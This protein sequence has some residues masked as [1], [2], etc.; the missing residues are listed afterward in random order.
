[1]TFTIQDDA[2]I[3]GDETAVLTISNP[4]AGVT[5]GTTTTQN[6]AI[7]DNDFPTVELSVSTN[8]GTEAAGTVVTVTAT[9]SQAVDGDQT[10]DLGVSGTGIAN[11]D[12]TLSNATITILDGATTDMVTFTVQD[13]ADIEGDETAMLTISNP[14]AGVT[15]GTT[16]TQNVAITDNDFPTV[17]LSVSANSGTE[18]AG[19]VITVTATASQAVDGD[20]TVDLGVSGTG[21]ANTDYT[22]SNATITI[23]DGATTG[24]V[25][26][27]IQ[28]DAD[29]EGAETAT[30]TISNPSSGLILGTTTTQNVA[31][32]DNDFP[33]VELSVSAN[34]GTEAAQ[35]V[36]T[37]TATASQAVDGDQTVDLGVS[38]TGIAN[39]DYALSN[40]TITILDGATTGMITFTI[41]DDADIEGD[42][43]ATLTLSNP[44]AGVTL[45]TTTTQNVA[46]TDNDFPSVDL[47]VSANTGTE[48]AQTVI[49]VTATAS[50]AVDGDQIVDLGVSGTGIAGTDYTLSNTTITILDGQT[51]GTVTFTIQDD[52]DIEG[53]ET[54]TLT[55]SNPSAGLA[56]GTATT[57][58]VVITDDDMAGFTLVE[59]GGNTVVHE[60]G[61]T[62]D[63]TVVLDAKPTVD[64]T[65]TISGD[66]VTEATV[67][68][69]NLTFTTTNW[70]IP[71]AVTITGVDDGV[72]DGDVVSTIMVNPS[73]GD[74]GFDALANQTVSVTTIDDEGPVTPTVDLSVSANAGTEATGT[75]ITITATTSQAVTGDQTIDLGV[76]GTGITN[77]D[78]A[79]SNTT[80]TILNGQTTG[81]VTLTIQDDADI[82]GDETATLTISNPSA[83]VILGTTT[84]QNVIITD[85][86]FPTVDLSVSAN[87]GTEAAGTVITI[88]AIA[89]QAVDGDQTVDLGVSGTGIT[90]TDYTLSN[91]AITILNGQTTGT[92]TF[93]IQDDA[94]IEGD[95]TAVLTISNPSAGLTLGTTTTQNVT[96]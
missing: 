14:S 29:I 92:V 1:V 10:I 26:F 4:S 50:Q 9:A 8:A 46:I 37:V 48:A 7:T 60:S 72:N 20:Q 78:Y 61:T 65:F 88:T 52:A 18:A 42:E 90:N 80:I 39:T 70:N 5:L 24:L 28:D 87:V 76:S 91:V 75:V 40:A 89:S 55:I 77:T 43:T 12:Y 32:T 96:I 82:E 86:D 84:T 13:D 27:T 36:I 30:L 3:E 53:S 64:V 94:D 22:L 62:D 79:L 47:S 51:T 56:L 74:V 71:Q 19:T 67:S 69:V 58:N 85:N 35:T 44:S 68:P 16:T 2:D 54:A 59:S 95:E 45:G 25:T 57:Q 17:E 66:D 93:T 81:T 11:T 63:F 73:S 23:L 31:I 83:G 34:S 49:T 38:G 21:I 15:L 6:V 41:Q 33:T